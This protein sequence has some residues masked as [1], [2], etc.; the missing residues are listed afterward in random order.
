MA[1]EKIRCYDCE[2]FKPVG[3]G[4]SGWCQDTREGRKKIRANAVDSCQYAVRKDSTKEDKSN[5]KP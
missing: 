2:Y 4:F 5:G 3:R 1:E